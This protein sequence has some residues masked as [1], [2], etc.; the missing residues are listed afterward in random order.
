MLC[1]ADLQFLGWKLPGKRKKKGKYGSDYLYNKC[2]YL[3][4]YSNLTNE[5]SRGPQLSIRET[6]IK[7]DIRIKD[8]YKS[9]P[10]FFTTGLSLNLHLHCLQMILSSAQI[11]TFSRVDEGCLLNLFHN[12]PLIKS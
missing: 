9:A 10:A 12:P 6:N 2:R 7:R 8:K 11:L 5:S 1:L 3:I 4:M